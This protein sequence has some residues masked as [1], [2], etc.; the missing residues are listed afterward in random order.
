MYLSFLSCI[1]L[2][3]SV[4]EDSEEWTYYDD[5]PVFGSANETAHM[6]VLPHVYI[7]LLF[8][9]VTKLDC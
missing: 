1:Y 3:E 8:Y 4:S 2:F 9:S 6:W 5:D 7:R